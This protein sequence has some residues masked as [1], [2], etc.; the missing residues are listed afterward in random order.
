MLSTLE[1]ETIDIRI[2]LKVVG[3]FTKL[4]NK[5]WYSI[6][7]QLENK[8]WVNFIQEF[9]QTRDIMSQPEN[10]LYVW[11]YTSEEEVDRKIENYNRLKLKLEDAYNQSR[12]QS[13]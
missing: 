6:I 2:P 7:V 3:D 1:R 11:K 12:D 5:T 8:Q 4:E 10:E 9:Q 13:Y